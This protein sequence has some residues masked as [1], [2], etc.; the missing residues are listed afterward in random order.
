MKI[1]VVSTPVFPCPPSG[2][3]GLEMIAWLTAKGLAEKSHQVALVAPDGSYCPNVTMVSNGPAGCWDE[4]SAFANYWP[5]LLEADVIIDHSWQKWSMM[6]KGEKKLTAPVLSV[7]H[8]PADTMYKSPPPTPKPCFVCISKD[9][10][11]HLEALLPVK[12]RVAYNGV[13]TIHYQP[14]NIPRSDRFLFLARFSAIKG[15]DIALEACYQAGVGLDLIGDT[16]ITNEPDYFRQCMAMANRQSPNWDASK[17]KQFRIIGAVNRGEA[18]WWFS[19]AKAMI[20]PVVRFRE[21]FGLAP[22]ESMLC[23]TPVIAWDNGACRETVL[24]GVS[25]MLVNSMEGLLAA[26]KCEWINQIPDKDRGACRE[27]ASRFSVQAMVDR[28]EELAREAIET[29]GW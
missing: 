25:G 11:A 18:V 22:V 29:G 28:Y 8:A 19:Q 5:K 6:L 21:P 7:M 17:G 14:A 27:W 2:Y 24:P 23:G 16:S 9:Q 10:A 1:T 4:K 26:I 12:T 3:S 15:P 20:H 13:D